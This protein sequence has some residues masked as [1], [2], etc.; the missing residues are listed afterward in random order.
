VPSCQITNVKI[1]SASA[2]ASPNDPA[3]VVILGST[4]E[5]VSQISV[6][7]LSSG[8]ILSMN[9]LKGLGQNPCFR[10]VCTGRML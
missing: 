8:S 6:V 4:Y 2:Q 5:P 3:G 7:G 1:L 10:S 9:S